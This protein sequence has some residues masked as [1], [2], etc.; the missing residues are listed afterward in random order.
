MET[1]GKPWTAMAS[2]GRRVLHF[3]TD[4]IEWD[5]LLPDLETGLLVLN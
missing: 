3:L 5:V 2:M 4:P 1:I